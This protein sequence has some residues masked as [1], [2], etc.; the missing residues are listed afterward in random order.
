[1]AL[2]A[3]LTLLIGSMTGLVVGRW[4]LVLGLAAGIAPVALVAGL[5]AA[6]LGA[7][8]AAGFLAGAYLHGVV[9]EATRP[10]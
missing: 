10:A 5:E 8:G 6:A 1:M 9:A 7:L 4:H 2:V 3:V